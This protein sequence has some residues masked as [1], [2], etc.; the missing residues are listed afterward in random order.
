MPTCTH[1]GETEPSGERV[2]CPSCGAE[3]P[4][5]GGTKQTPPH[6]S[7]DPSEVDHGR[8]EQDESVRDR[9]SPQTETQQQSTQTSSNPATAQTENK[10]EEQLQSQSKEKQSISSQKDRSTD[11]LLGGQSRQTAEPEVN[12]IAWWFGWHPLITVGIVGIL[13]VIIGVVIGIGLEGVFVLFVLGTMIGT[14]VWYWG[15]KEINDKYTGT[16]EAFFGRSAKRAENRLGIDKSEIIGTFD[17][18]SHHGGSPFLVKP[19]KF[20]RSDHLIFSDVSVSVDKDSVY[21]M[22]ERTS[23]STGTTKNVYYDNIETITT[24]D[25]GHQTYLKIV[26]SRGENL[27][28]ATVDQSVA[29]EAQGTLRSKMREV[30]R[31]RR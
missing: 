31:N 16:R 8:E 13:F 20:Y 6:S 1:C 17:F 7:S 2:Y 25:E 5:D 28:A 18:R 26:T 22:K 3:L 9:N 24:N 14:G 12:G 29:E 10:R 30:K 19:S 4:S 27:R 21:N 23:S 15:V 11:S